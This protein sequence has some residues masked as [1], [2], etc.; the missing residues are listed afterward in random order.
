MKQVSKEKS[1]K[2]SLLIRI[3]FLKVL[4]REILYCIVRIALFEKSTVFPTANPLVY[5]I[6]QK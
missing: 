4:E 1:L 6:S 2:G 5:E 3:E